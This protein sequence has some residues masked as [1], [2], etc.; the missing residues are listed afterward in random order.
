[1]DNLR[2]LLP[3]GS[4]VA[5]RGGS[6]KLMI[7]GVKQR[8]DEEGAVFDYIGVPFPEGNIGLEGQFFFQ[9]EDIEQVYFMGCSDSEWDSFVE[10]LERYYSGRNTPARN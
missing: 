3:I 8:A 10:E 1:M 2:E 5:L 6:K 7:F 9:H 4:V